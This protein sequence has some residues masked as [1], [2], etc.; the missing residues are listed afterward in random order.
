MRGR[1]GLISGPVL[2]YATGGL[3]YGQAQLNANLVSPATFTFPASA[4]A[5]KTG[6]IAGGGAEWAFAGNWSAK[7]EGLYY[8]LGNTTVLAGPTLGAGVPGI[9][10]FLR[11]RDFN[12]TG[13]IVRVG[14][15]YRV[16]GPVVA[17][18]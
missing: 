14:V 10:G 18:Y 15:N 5:T 12:L 17:R 2:L 4:S 9:T 6:W 7:L 13:G 1:V 8:D 16:G 3:A 11:G